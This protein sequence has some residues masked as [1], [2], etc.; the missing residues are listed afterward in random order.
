MKVKLSR[1]RRG[2]VYRI[3]DH[4]YID[5][6][7][8]GRRMREATEALTRDEAKKLRAVRLSDIEREQHFNLP[9]ARQAVMLHDL[10]DEYMEQYAKV[11]KRSW[12]RDRSSIKHILAFFGNVPAERISRELCE[13]F[14]K[15]RATFLAA[16]RVAEGQEDGS[17]AE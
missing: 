2:G 1:K 5:Y 17:Q 11:T 13:N 14:K 16:A 8:Q 4:W 7:F 6:Y 3:G 10:C 9:V 12:Q 15:E